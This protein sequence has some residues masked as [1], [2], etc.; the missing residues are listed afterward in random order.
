M[1]VTLHHF[2]VLIVVLIITVDVVSY[3][4]NLSAH[5]LCFS[6]LRAAQP[7]DQHSS[8]DPR[9]V[10]QIRAGIPGP[11]PQQGVS[12]GR[13]PERPPAD[14]VIESRIFVGRNIERKPLARRVQPLSRPGVGLGQRRH[15]QPA[16]DQERRKSCVD[17]P[18]EERRLAQVSCNYYF[19]DFNIAKYSGAPCT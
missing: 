7:A 17:A 10:L 11:Q 19:S 15:C 3:Q 6:R 2:V 5:V 4:Q 18:E 1:H 9:A 14:A 13:D 12:I 8:A 16:L